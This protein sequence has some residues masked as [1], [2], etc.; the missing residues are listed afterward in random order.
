MTVRI[1][2]ALSLLIA[3]PGCKEDAYA[4]VSVLTGSG[5]LSGVAQFRVYVDNGSDSGT[6]YYPRQPTESLVLDTT[7]PVTFSVQFSTS[8][9]GEARFEVE[10][11]D[12]AGTVLGYGEAKAAIEKEKV[13]KVTVRVTPGAVRPVQ[14]MDGGALACDPY[15]PAL[16]CGAGQTCGLL[17]SAGQPA[18]GMCYVAGLA[19]P[20]QACASNNDCS[21]GSQ[22]FTFSAIGGCQVMTCLRFCG[23]DAACGE[24]GAYCNLKIPCDTDFMAC[25]RPCDPTGIGTQGCAAGL[26]CYVYSDETTDCACPGLG[27]LGSACSQNHGCDGT[28]ATCAGCRAG[29]SCVVPSGTTTGAG[30][31]RPICSLAAATTT[32]PSG[33]CHAFAGSTNFP[34]GFCE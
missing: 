2:L 21:P 27:T 12:V 20:G 10:P 13:F 11:L 24:T 28:T 4:L 30:V 8:R 14:V 7:N 22:C 3:L 6:L 23:S 19:V 16:A 32:C 34:Y 18:V 33:T 15:Q 26:A 25:S 9:G 31:C 29:L 1:S 17:C 5:T